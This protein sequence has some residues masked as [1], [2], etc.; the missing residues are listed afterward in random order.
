MKNNNKRVS[1][2]RDRL[3]AILLYVP[4]LV[5]DVGIVLMKVRKWEDVRKDTKDLLK[6]VWSSDEIKVS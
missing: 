5:L 3:W 2:W 4:L 6:K 1:I